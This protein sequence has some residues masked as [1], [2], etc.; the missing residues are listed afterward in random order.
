[1]T[2]DELDAWL[3]AWMHQ[4]GWNSRWFGL[5]QT[6]VRDLLEMLNDKTESSEGAG[7]HRRYGA[8]LPTEAK[9]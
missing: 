6:F 7:R 2:D 3:R 8:G 4:G 9:E 5:F 1:V